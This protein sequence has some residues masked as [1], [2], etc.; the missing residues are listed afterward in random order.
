M[1]VCNSY[2]PT[3]ESPERETYA[4][5]IQVSDVDGFIFKSH[6][7]T[8][9]PP[10]HKCIIKE[11]NWTLSPFLR[12]A[13]KYLSRFLVKSPFQLWACLIWQMCSLCILVR[14]VLWAPIH[15]SI[16]TN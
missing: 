2:F 7:L 16:K 8:A 13:F 4:F 10:V 6:F 11:T 9:P 1:S 15:P 14:L 12:L 3:S 5:T